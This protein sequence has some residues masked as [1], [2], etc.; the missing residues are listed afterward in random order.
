MGSIY[1]EIEIEDFTFDPITQLF[2]YPCPCGDKFAIGI[3]DL[4]DGE[5]IAVCPSCSLMVK[6]IFEPE[7]LEEYY[8]QLE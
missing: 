3:D 4:A 5:E 8:E 7:D 2:Q 1:D 6:V